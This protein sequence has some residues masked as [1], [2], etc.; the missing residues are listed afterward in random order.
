MDYELAAQID[1]TLLKADA[2]RADILRVCE[3]AKT[4]HT[5]SVCVNAF[6]GG[7]SLQKRLQAAAS[8]RAVWSGFRWGR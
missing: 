4:Y 2:T 1:H 6:W 8:R 7:P 5:A 3:E